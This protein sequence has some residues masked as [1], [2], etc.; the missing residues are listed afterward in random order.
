M[1][2]GLTLDSG[3][4]IAAEKGDRVFWALWKKAMDRRAR[5][6]KVCVR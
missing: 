2:E 5:R 6:L 4:L 1:A 3:A